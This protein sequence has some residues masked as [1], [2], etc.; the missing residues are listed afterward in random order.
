MSATPPRARIKYSRAYQPPQ[1]DQRPPRPPSRR[2]PA[3]AWSAAVRAGILAGGL[4][5]AALLLVSQFTTLYTVQISSS[6]TIV[7]SVS[8]SSHDSYALIPIAIVVAILTLGAGLL[9]SRL[10]LL[11]LGALGIVTLL[12]ALVGDLPDAQATGAVNYAGH[13]QNATASPSTGLYLETLGAVLLIIVSGCGLL[14]AGAAPA[15]RRRAARTET[16]SES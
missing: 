5:S 11:A 6:G 13:F 3:P 7:A 1:A 15:K 4:L 9:G 14:L 16:A 12:I 10:S 8:T 2:P